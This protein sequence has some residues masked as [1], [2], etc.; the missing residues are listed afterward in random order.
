MN[1]ETP[2][3]RSDPSHDLPLD[4]PEKSWRTAT[5][6]VHAGREVDPSTGAVVP[7]IY[8]S[9]TFSRGPDAELMGPYVYSRSGNPNRT[10]LER[11]VAELEGGADAAAF[12][13]GL[14]AANAIL[15]CL[16]AGDRVLFSRDLYHGVRTLME[17]VTVRSGVVCEAIDLQ[18]DAAVARELHRGVRAVWCETPTNPKLAVIDLASLAARCRAA[19]ADLIVDNSFATPVLQRPLGLGAALVVHSSTKYLAGHSDVTGGVVVTQDTT[20]ELWAKLRDVQVFA[21][22]VPSPMDC[23]LTLRGIATLSVRMKQHVE[24]ALELARRF[25]AHGSV[26]HTLYPGLQSHASYELAARQMSGPGGVLSIRLGGGEDGARRF[27]SR[28]TWIPRATSLGGTHTLVEHRT[29]VEP[30]GSPVPRDLVRISVGIED[31][32]DLWMEFERAL[33]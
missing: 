5:R 1:R 7:P 15:Q 18:D 16:C 8:M 24:N 2:P 23:W 11:C 28:L 9:T 10:G 27:A 3:E 30:E 32:E 19:G 29:L 6:V 22:A 33:G 21:G 12:S 25:E 20:S 26:V 4:K 17:K 14:A 13:S 31:V